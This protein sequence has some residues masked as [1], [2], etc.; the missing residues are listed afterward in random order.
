[1]VQR[2]EIDFNTAKHFVVLPAFKENLSSFDM[3]C[4][5]GIKNFCVVWA[6]I[7]FL[8]CGKKNKS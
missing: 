1:M 2:T 5:P 8:Y 7:Y 4:E 3:R 6:K